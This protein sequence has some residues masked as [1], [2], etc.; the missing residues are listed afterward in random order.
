MNTA[1]VA[2]ENVNIDTLPYFFQSVITM[3]MNSMKNQKNRSGI[4]YLINS[5]QNSLILKMSQKQSIDKEKEDYLRKQLDHA[6]IGQE[7]AIKNWTTASNE[8]SKIKSN[9]NRLRGVIIDAINVMP[10]SNAKK[11]LLA[12]YNETAD[13]SL[14]END[15]DAIIKA[16]YFA[17]QGIKSGLYSDYK[18]ALLKYIAILEQKLETGS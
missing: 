7:C 4:E 9:L 10:D 1:R 12:A 18:S 6:L 8:R 3:A 13:Q 5:D 17:D 2:P 11:E 14:I 16:I 15:I